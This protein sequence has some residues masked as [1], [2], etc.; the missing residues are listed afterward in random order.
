MKM[1]RRAACAGFAAAATLIGAEAA[2]Q[3]APAITPAAFAAWLE[4]YK[5]AWETR[6]ASLAG[7]L[8]TE[9][10]TYHEK[11]FDAPMQGRPAIEAYWTRVTAGQ[12]DI[13]F[14]Y[15]V[16]A[17]AGD[18]GVAHWHAAF[19]VEGGA[20]IELDGVFVCAFADAETVR[21]LREWWDVQATAPEQ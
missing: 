3:D 2:A 10:A 9:D 17:C 5:Q 1:N 11:P 18:Q 13:H 6:D 20:R 15:E 14:T 12:S 8:F 16:I 4:R 19:L 7:A 21:H